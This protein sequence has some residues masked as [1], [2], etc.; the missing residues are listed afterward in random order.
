[1]DTECK[2]QTSARSSKSFLFLEPAV[3]S[4]RLAITLTNIGW[5]II[6]I[7]NADNLFYEV[8]GK[9]TGRNVRRWPP[10]SAGPSIDRCR[11]KI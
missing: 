8:L 1:M 11:E 5:M 4:P 6:E 10:A 3:L 2:A 7:P 9:A